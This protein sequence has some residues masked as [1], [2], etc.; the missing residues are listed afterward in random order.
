MRAQIAFYMPALV[1]MREWKLLFSISKDGVSFNTFYLNLKNRDNTVLLIKDEYGKVFGAYNCDEWHKS[2]GF[3]G[4]GES[5][6][7]NFDQSDD[8]IAA[9]RYTGANEKIQFS[10]ERCIIIGG[11]SEGSQKSEA[12]LFINKEFKDGHSG[13][14]ET[15]WNPILST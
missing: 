4:M 9:Y 15:F 6:V 13:E 11:G 1:R 10:D 5:F 3:Y 2:L 14:S 12:A 7:F 8:R